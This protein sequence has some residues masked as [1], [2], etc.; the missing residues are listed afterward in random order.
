MSLTGVPVKPHYQLVMEKA[1]DGTVG[2][3]YG[4]VE[5]SNHSHSKEYPFTLPTTVCSIFS[6]QHP[7]ISI[8]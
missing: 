8:G 7:L 2:M 4:D 1:I 3:E 6:A 5:D